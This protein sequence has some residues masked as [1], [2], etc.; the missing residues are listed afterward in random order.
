MLPE[1]RQV[2]ASPWRTEHGTVRPLTNANKPG[3]AGRHCA[4]RNMQMT[5]FFAPKRNFSSLSV[6][7]LLEARDAYHVHLAHLENVVATAIGLY[8]IRMDDP[9]S[10]NPAAVD[11]HD[12]ASRRNSPE[13]TLANTVTKKW[14][15]P[16]VL[17][18]VDE[19]QTQAHF[20]NRP[21]Q[22]VPR[23]LYLP[24]GRVVPTCVILAEESEAAAPLLQDLSFPSDLMGGGYPVLTDVQGTEHVGSVGCLVT[25]GDR[26]Y[27]LTNRHVSGDPGREIYS[28]IR[29]R[30]QRVGVAA[31]TQLGKM[32]FHKAFPGWP[33]T[34]AFSNLDVGLIEVDDVNCWTTQVYGVGELDLPVDLNVDTISLDLIGCPVRAFGAASGEMVGQIQALF[35]RYKSIGGFDYVTDLLIGPLNEKTPM[36]TMPGDSGTLWVFDPDL[37]PL[38]DEAAGDKSVTSLPEQ[39][40][41]KAGTRARRLRPVALQWGGHR[42]MNDGDAREMCFALATCLSSVCR[43]LDVEVMRDWNVGHSEYWG[44]TGHYLIGAKACE[45]VTDSKLRKLL[46]ANKGIIAF[47]DIALARSIKKLD[48]TKFVPLADVPDL[49]WR[50]TRKKDESNHFADMDQPGPDGKDLLTLCKDA[51]NVD[52]AV[53]IRFY[54]SIQVKS[55]RGALPFRVWQFYQEMVAFVKAGKVAEYLC[56]AGILAHYVGDACQPLHVSRL[57]HGHPDKPN[58]NPVHSTYETSMLDRRA[59]ELLT[60]V[61]AKVRRVKLPAKFTGG[62]QAAMAVIDLMRHTFETLPPEEVIDAF[63]AAAGLQRIPHMWDVLHD[64]TTTCIAGGCAV[65]AGIWQSAWVEGN[66]GAIPTN[67]LGAA[68]PGVMTTLY[69]T[70]SFLEAF[71]LQ[72]MEQKKI[73][74]S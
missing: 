6:L 59:A 60:E 37:A 54:E 42:I 41:V 66:G 43:E 10:K 2:F 45:M 28:M 9:D 7:D 31:P 34:R 58:E 48:A 8:R 50:M 17:V 68:D 25:D 49:V 67:K 40:S 23:L 21:D 52:V 19:W 46:A 14:S 61:N 71:T 64:R 53:W 56:A 13:R 72:E 51:A 36:K 15:W 26:T 38:T 16:C 47:D 65:L 20:H 35:Y 29:S 44:Q 5:S 4:T 30:R 57:H 33:E 55:K 73:L 27:A 69:N 74:K 32:P 22:A 18:F 39:D 11:P 1:S 3:Q 70:K 62:K 12:P 63:N 24:D